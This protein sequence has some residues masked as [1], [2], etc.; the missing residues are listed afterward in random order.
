MLIKIWLKD[1]NFLS[2][3]IA[4]YDIFLRFRTLFDNMYKKIY[5]IQIL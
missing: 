4:K 3:L 5:N 2:V 1:K